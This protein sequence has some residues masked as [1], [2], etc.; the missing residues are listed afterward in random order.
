MG[1]D[2][3]LKI[4][5]AAAVSSIHAAAGAEWSFNFSLSLPFSSSSL[6]RACSGGRRQP[7][8]AYT[9]T[10]MQ[11][12]THTY[13]IHVQSRAVGLALNYSARHAT[14]RLSSAGLPLPPS[15]HSERETDR[16]GERER[17][18]AGRAGLCVA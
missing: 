14:A 4:A 17:D 11:I 5:S 13:M 3:T 6:L 8:V 2:K 1:K 7:C 16:G 10:C 18:A 9:D 12:H 15:L